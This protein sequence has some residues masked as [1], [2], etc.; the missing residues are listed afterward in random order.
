MIGLL[1]AWLIGPPLPV[2]LDVLLAQAHIESRFDA[3][4][5]SRV[6]GSRFCGI[7]QTKAAT[8]RECREMQLP[9]VALRA[10]DRE[11]RAWLLATRGDLRASLRG[12]A[13]GW[14]ASRPGGECRGYD[15][16]VL[17]LARRIRI[18]RLNG[19]VAAMRKRVG[20]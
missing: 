17:A 16:R 2:S 10:Y 13:C 18:A 11:L 4:A 19:Q 1:F 6:R 7:L 9:F 5:V 3:T 20:S 8:E 12:Y 14:A 15:R